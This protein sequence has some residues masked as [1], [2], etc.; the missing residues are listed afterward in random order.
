MFTP[1]QAV[2][3][4]T[5]VVRNYLLIAA[6]VIVS[7]LGVSDAFMAPSRI[8]QQGRLDNYG[9]YLGAGLVASAQK[10]GR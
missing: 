6:V 5:T 4:A 10:L 9:Q 8:A 7:S 2:N 1:N 3:P